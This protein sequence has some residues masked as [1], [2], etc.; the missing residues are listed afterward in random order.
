MGYLV[1]GVRVCLWARV[2]DGLG[3]AHRSMCVCMRERAHTVWVCAHVCVCFRE[4]WQVTH[5]YERERERERDRER[6]CVCMCD[7]VC[8][9]VSAAAISAPSA[10]SSSATLRSFPHICSNAARSCGVDGQGQARVFGQ[11]QARYAARSQV[12]DSQT[13]QV[14]CRGEGQRREPLVARRRG[15]HLPAREPLS[16]GVREEGRV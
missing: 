12:F 10:I 5:V 2:W 6:E 4:A 1:L 3:C 11:A 8:V 9:C 13:T 14:R 7:T 16:Q 15:T